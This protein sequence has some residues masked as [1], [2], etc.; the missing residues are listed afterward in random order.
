MVKKLFITRVDETLLE[1]MKNFCGSRGIK[2]TFFVSEAIADKLKAMKEIE[3]K[4]AQMSAQTNQDQVAN[5]APAGQVNPAPAT[6]VSAGSENPDFTEVY[7]RGIVYYNKGDYDQAIKEFTKAIE[8]NPGFAEAYGNRGTTYAHQKMFT[9]A[10]DD[11]YQA[12]ILF[13]EQGRKGDALKCISNMK[14]ADPTSPL[15]K[16]LMDKIDEQK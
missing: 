15:I 13:L 2:I 10:C 7:N 9:V 5:Q 12:G 14:Q 6:P 1:S 3:S 11:F 4:I 16:K 8:L